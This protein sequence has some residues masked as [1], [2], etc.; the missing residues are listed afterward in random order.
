M[1]PPRGWL[2]N[3]PLSGLCFIFSCHPTLSTDRDTSFQ[4]QHN[5]HILLIMMFKTFNEFSMPCEVRV[6]N[7]PYPRLSHQNTPEKLRGCLSS[8]PWLVCAIETSQVAVRHFYPTLPTGKGQAWRLGLHHV[9][10]HYFLCY[11]FNSCV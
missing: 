11:F 8:E 4:D 6:V 1:L 3:P 9:I 5:P 2:W 10:I 7:P